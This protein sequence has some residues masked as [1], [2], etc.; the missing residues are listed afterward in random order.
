MN[1][2]QNIIRNNISCGNMLKYINYLEIEEIECTVND[3]YGVEEIY[4]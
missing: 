1:I 2:F 4:E 3:T